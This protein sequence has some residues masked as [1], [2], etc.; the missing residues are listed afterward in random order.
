MKKN[1][2]KFKGFTLAEVSIALAVGSIIVAMTFFAFSNVYKIFNLKAYYSTLWADYD[3]LKQ[4]V[5]TFESENLNYSKT[6]SENE[7][8]Y[9]VGENQTNSLKFL[10]N[11][12][13]INNE[14]KREFQ[15][16]KQIQIV[17]NCVQVE[18]NN[19]ENLKFNIG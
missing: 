16:I 5:S 17:S 15:T 11:Q 2:K 7:I 14:K 19:N 3:S 13:L 8:T 9:A 1:I 10:N 18:F 4:I 12:V 6:L